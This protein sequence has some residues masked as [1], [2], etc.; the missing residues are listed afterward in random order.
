MLQTHHVVCYI[1][2]EG[3]A[4]VVQDQQIEDLKKLL[5]QNDFDV[6]ITPEN[7]EIGKKAEIIRGP[8]IGLKGELCE[9]RGKHK[10]LLRIEQIDKSFVVEVPADYLSAIPENQLPG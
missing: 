4:A 6:E 2:F 9:I 3:K 8:M 7:C 10:F 5:H 1:T